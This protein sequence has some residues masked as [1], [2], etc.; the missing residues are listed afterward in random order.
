LFF[1]RYEASQLGHIAIE[2][3]HLLLGLLRESDGLANHILSKA[4]VS[5]DEVL[6]DVKKRRPSIEK[7][8]T[9][10]EIPFAAETKRVL[11]YAAEESNRLLVDYIG[12]EHLLLGL[13]RE[14]ACLAAGILRARGLRIG[15]VRDDIVVSLNQSQRSSQSQQFEVSGAGSFGFVDEFYTPGLRL[16][17]YT[18]P[19]REL[20]RNVL[21]DQLFDG[22][23]KDPQAKV[24]IYNAEI[25][26][27]GYT[28]WHCHN[29]A[30]FFIALQ[31]V[32]EA[33]F[34]EGVLVKAKAGDVYSEPIGK[35][36]RGH[37]PDPTTAYLC[38]GICIT[39]PD[40]EHVTNVDERPW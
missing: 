19:G 30:T 9:S 8:P 17:G 36:H 7:L 32:F 16:S 40:R 18:G 26:P 14:E 5:R 11:Q 1:S 25:A 37:N 38:I 35:F 21:Y 22:L 29:G 28:N 3:E 4:T 24:Q 27:G 23:P 10:V 6:K 39:P 31:G 12:P 34:E 33:E 2:T 13:M 20:H 15:V